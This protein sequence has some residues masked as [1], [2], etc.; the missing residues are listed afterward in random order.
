[1][2]VALYHFQHYTLDDKKLIRPAAEALLIKLS[3]NAEFRLGGN[4][5]TDNY[6]NRVM[7]QGNGMNSGEHVEISSNAFHGN[8]GPF[9][10]IEIVNVHTVII[11]SNAFYSKFL[12]E[13]FL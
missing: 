10:E 8:T 2:F 5:L 12:G 9:P 1:M 3:R 6:L 13:I 11:R 4:V 7:I